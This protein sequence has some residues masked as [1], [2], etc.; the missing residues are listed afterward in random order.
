M[1]T[2]RPTPRLLARLTALCFGLTTLFPAHAALDI[3]STP[4]Q[5]S[6]TT[7]PNVM[8]I[9]D[10]SGSMH[11]EIMPDELTIATFVFPRADGIYGGSDYDNRVATVD[12]NV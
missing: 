8:M 1:K 2:L 9:L 12:N 4:L 7:E 5:T 6:L 3:P 10:D 11:W